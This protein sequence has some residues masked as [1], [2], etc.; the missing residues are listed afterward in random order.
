MHLT[1]RSVV[2]GSATLAAVATLPFPIQAAREPIVAD[3]FY[4]IDEPWGAFVRG[5]VSK[6]EFDKAVLHMLE[7][8]SDHRENGEDWLFEYRYD[9]DEDER[10]II[11]TA[12]PEYMHMRVLEVDPDLGEQYCFCKGAA[13]GAIPISVARY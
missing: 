2:L 7:T 9:D 5:H 13:P 6:T 8:D 11:V 1:R 3:M 12:E 10:M 4:S